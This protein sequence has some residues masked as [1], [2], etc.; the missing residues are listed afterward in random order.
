[1][2]HRVPWLST[3]S[4]LSLGQ[5]AMLVFCT[6]LVARFLFAVAFQTW[7]FID[8]WQFGQEI[9]RIGRMLVER[10]EF[11]VEAGKPT[12]K[13]PPIY[14]PIVALVFSIFGVYSTPSAL[15]LFFLQSVFAGLAAVCLLNLGT[16][17][18]SRT[19]GLLAG[20]GWALYPSS[21]FESTAQVWYSELSILLLL[22][23]ILFAT[24]LTSQRLQF[25]MA[26]LGGLSGVLLLTDSSM[27]SYAVIIPVW[28]LVSRRIPWK[29]WAWPLAAWSLAAVVVVSPWALRNWRMFD[30]PNVLKSNFGLELFFGNNP[31]SSGG[32]LD[33]ERRQALTAVLSPTEFAR[34][35]DGMEQLYYAHLRQEAIA[36]IQGHPLA[37][38]RLTA[39]R[40]WNYWG[41][42]PSSGPD[43][44]R[45]YSWFHFVWY[46]PVVLLAVAGALDRSKW[47]AELF[48]LMLFL[49]VYPLPYYITHVQLY[50]YRY[51]VEPILILLAAV[52]VARRLDHMVDDAR[53]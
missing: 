11:A 46:L 19:V 44:F 20:F 17:F 36:W 29:A 47:R 37:F 18:L 25:R 35:Q 4:R 31:F 45:H 33:S 32:T 21:L 41:K 52:P 49:L 26:I 28:V 51:P 24:T 8:N 14:P 13:F 43:R 27:L 30:S 15:V 2:T 53:S 10:G 38:L 22:A 6:A 5:A 48:L 23:I 9:G 7:D 1:M 34:M 16:R 40:I 12:A 42:F 39:I 50:R 3:L